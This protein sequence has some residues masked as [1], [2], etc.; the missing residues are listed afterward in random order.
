MIDRLYLYYKRCNLKH[1]QVP[2]ARNTYLNAQKGLFLRPPFPPQEH[3]HIQKTDFDV[4]EV[5]I[6]NCYIIAEEGEG[7]KNLWPVIYKFKIPY[8]LA[9]EFIRELDNRKGINLTTLKPNLDNIIR[10]KKFRE[11]VNNLWAELNKKS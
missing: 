9:P 10:Y 7:F 4:K 2:T 8:E 3:D 5:A 6:S 1:F 11:V